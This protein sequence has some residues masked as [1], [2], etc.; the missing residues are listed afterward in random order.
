VIGSHKQPNPLAW[1]RQVY[2]A[3]HRFVIYWESMSNANA[4][5]EDE[6]ASNDIGPVGRETRAAPK[7]ILETVDS[8][9]NDAEGSLVDRQV[10][11]LKIEPIG[12][13]GPCLV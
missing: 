9:A 3:G 1:H 5:D 4:L 6:A 13:Y 2:R 8:D 12:W 7:L 10:H 11:K